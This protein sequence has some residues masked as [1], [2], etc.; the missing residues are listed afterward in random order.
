MTTP[1]VL[2]P[3]LDGTEVFCRPLVAELARTVDVRVVTLPV[4]LADYDALLEHVR[5]E[6]ADLDALHVVGWSF[7][8]PL[9]L[10]LGVTEPGRVRSVTLAASFVV[11]PRAA[12]ARWHPFVRGPLFTT[13][14]ALRRAALVA[15]R[16][17]DDPFVRDKLETWRR[18]RGGDL[19]RR[20]RVIGRVDARDDLRRCPAPIGYLASSDDAVVPRRNVDTI[21][22][23]RPDVAVREIAGGHYALYDAP[24][25]AADALTAL[26]TR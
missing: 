13:W 24:R 2:L 5:A 21:R 14:R 25:A 9:A 19:A 3:G 4:S 7:S 26:V 8:G 16:P 15:T 18:V 23:V 6:V 1:I 10:K 22:A 20:L 17:A 11:P 12:L